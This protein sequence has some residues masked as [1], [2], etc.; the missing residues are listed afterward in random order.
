M[1]WLFLW[2]VFFCTLQFI[3]ALQAC[4]LVKFSAYNNL[5]A[6]NYCEVNENYLGTFKTIILGTI[7]CFRHLQDALEW[8][9]LVLTPLAMTAIPLKQS[10]LWV[11]SW[12]MTLSNCPTLGQPLSRLPS[13]RPSE[14][15]L[16]KPM[17]LVSWRC[18]ADTWGVWLASFPQSQH[19]TPAI[20]IAEGLCTNP[21]M[22]F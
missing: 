12:G 4:I 5:K 1:I 21:L 13:H 6:R 7:G 15:S 9:W 11:F 18:T 8:V 19:K 14:C 2:L 20:T 10:F 22:A 3:R 17:T 16:L